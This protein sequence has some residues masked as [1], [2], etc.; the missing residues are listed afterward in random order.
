MWRKPEASGGNLV[1]TL[2]IS[3]PSS[4]MNLASSFGVDFDLA[5]LEACFLVTDVAIGL[6][7]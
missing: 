5:G 4:S 2:P 7:A 3:A 1:T 6:L